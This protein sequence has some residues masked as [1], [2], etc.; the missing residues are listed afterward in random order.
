[1]QTGL[2]I[3]LAVFVLLLTRRVVRAEVRIG[4]A[5]AVGLGNPSE[6]TD[7]DTTTERDLGVEG[8]LLDAGVFKSTRGDLLDGWDTE[9]ARLEAGVFK[10][11]RGDLLDDELGSAGGLKYAGASG[12][13]PG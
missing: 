13:N 2:L 8:T 1:M 4:G 12:S 9:D 5:D 6:L 11:T 7:G 3:F 10:S